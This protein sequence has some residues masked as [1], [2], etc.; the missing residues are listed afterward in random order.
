MHLKIKKKA[1]FQNVY[2][3]HLSFSSKILLNYKVFEIYIKTELEGTGRYRKV[4][5]LFI[6]FCHISNLIPFIVQIIQMKKKENVP[7]SNKVITV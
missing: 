7:L 6:Y 3:T 5:Y 2:L 1:L 4:I